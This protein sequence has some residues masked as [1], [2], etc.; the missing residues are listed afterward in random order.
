MKKIPAL[1]LFMTVPEQ[2]W[3]MNYSVRK[4]SAHCEAGLLNYLLSPIRVT[5]R[6]FDIPKLICTQSSPM[7]HSG[8][9]GAPVSLPP[10][11][12]CRFFV[13][14]SFLLPQ[15]QCRHVLKRSIPAR[16]RKDL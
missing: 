4:V 12:K 16:Y 2:C 8:S 7:A 11:V 6:R 3:V 1:G 10:Q 13:I 5:T 15:G 9:R 14:Q